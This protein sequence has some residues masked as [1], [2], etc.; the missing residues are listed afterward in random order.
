MAD[1]P[2]DGT[3]RDPDRLAPEPR[4]PIYPGA[5]RRT[6][7][8]RRAFYPT[9]D[10]SEGNVPRHLW[11]L[12]WPQVTEGFL[13]ITVQLAE[14]V[15]VGR[16]GF[17]AIAGL[18]VGQTYMMLIVAIRSG[19]DAVTRAMIARSIGARR[20]A[21]ANHVLLQALTLTALFSVLVITLG[22]LFTRPMLGVLGLSDAVVEQASGYMRVQYVTI[23]FASFQMLTAGALQA[24]GNSLTPLKAD[25]AN[26]AAHFVLSPL[27]IFGW[28]GLP[29]LGLVGAAVAAL[30]GRVLAAGLNFYA[31]SKGTSR[32]QLNLKRYKLDLG[33]IR[34]MVGIGIPA[35]VTGM[36]RGLSQLVVM[37]IVA[38]FGDA[39]LAAFSTMRRAETIAN[40]SSVGLGRSAGAL[41]GQNLGAGQP[42]R[43]KSAMRWA[44]LY[45]A[46]PS[47]ALTSVFLLFP[48]E[49]VSFV[50]SDPEFVDLA[51]QWVRIFAVGYFSITAVQV[52]THAF[53]T[54]G[55][56]VAPMLITVGALWLFEIPL[57]LALSNLTSLGQ[58]GV[59]WAIVAGSTLRLTVL[60]WY[61]GRG[62]WLR[63]GTL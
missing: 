56:T 55:E 45:G 11:Y 23:A 5:A 3:D 63:T 48:R 31:L 25:T 49:V 50:N 62:S 36:Q 58:F 43:A 22:L 39:P 46:V 44:V 19:L 42:R 33:L 38:T 29:A 7:G 30:V 15:W 57:A 17:Q 47:A 1:Q 40:Q 41:A 28:L 37:G 2:T 34:S 51:S 26:R 27:L 35:S 4:P 16:L 12:A 6:A 54:S 59:P 9:R 61:F 24:S 21:H 10:F 52:F 53:N 20:P 13:A 32:L 18:G 8:R 14:L 60:A